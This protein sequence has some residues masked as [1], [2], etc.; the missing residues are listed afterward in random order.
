MKHNTGLD[1]QGKVERVL[2]A[3]GVHTSQE[4]ALIIGHAANTVRRKVLLLQKAGKV[5]KVGAILASD[6]AASA[7]PSTVWAHID[8]EEADDFMTTVSKAKTNTQYAMAMRATNVGL[9]V[10]LAKIRMMAPSPFRVSMAQM[11]L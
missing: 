9:D 4:L 8:N 11:S 1:I 6:T 2:K 5:K 10:T 7:K 3:G